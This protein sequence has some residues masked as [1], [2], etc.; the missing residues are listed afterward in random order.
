[1]KQIYTTI[2]ALAM[3]FGMQSTVMAETYQAWGAVLFAYITSP[4]Y[5]A[6]ETIEVTGET[7]KFHSNTWGDG[8]FA[9]A[10]G[11]GTLTMAGHGGTKDYAADITGS[12]ESKQFVIS[13]PSVMGG[14]T[15]T[16]TLGDM[17][18]AAAV[19]GSYKGGTY[20]NAAYFKKYSPAADQTVTIKANEGLE[21][22]SVS[23]V[24]ETWGTFTYPAVTVTAGEDGSFSLEGEGTCAMP[25]M[26]GGGVNDYASD[27]KGTVKDG[28]LVAEFIVPSVMGGTTVL[29]NPADFDEVIAA[30]VSTIRSAETDL[31]AYNL[32]GLRVDSNYK[33]IVI[34]GGKKIYQK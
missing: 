6:N 5:D 3:L 14:T 1:M 16:V 8:V 7:I 28:V 11:E 24:S 29:F 13:V 19:D 20:A 25:S 9:A 21:S 18:A 2:I 27:F 4:M 33:G 17:P 12:V 30:S 22:V 26:Q 32:N 15:I 31:P 23:H 10:T 34:K